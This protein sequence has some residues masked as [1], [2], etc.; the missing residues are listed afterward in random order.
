MS[1]LKNLTIAAALVTVAATSTAASAGPLENLERERAILIETLLDP[2]L[3]PGDRQ[4]K[5]EM[6]KARLVD[7]E[8]IVLAGGP[9]G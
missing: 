5:L 7:L 6:A 1:V 9:L 2:E 3:A 8:R 4:A